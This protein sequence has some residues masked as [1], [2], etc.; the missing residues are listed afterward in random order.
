MRKQFA[1]YLCSPNYIMRIMWQ[2]SKMEL[3][4]ANYVAHD[5]Q[6][7]D[8]ESMENNANRN[9][10]RCVCCGAVVPEGTMVCKCCELEPVRPASK[11]KSTGSIL[12]KALDH[13]CKRRRKNGQQL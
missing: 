7:E 8:P 5:G 3:H 2:V 4:N 6:K 9:S 13:R 10:D 11:T 1:S 12:S